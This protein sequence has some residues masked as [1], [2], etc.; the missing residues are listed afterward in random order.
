MFQ[1]KQINKKNLNKKKDFIKFSLPIVFKFK[2]EDSIN[3][4]K[5]SVMKGL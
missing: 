5:I 3:I 4:K 1:L 2:Y